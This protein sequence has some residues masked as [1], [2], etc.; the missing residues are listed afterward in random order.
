MRYSDTELLNLDITWFAVD[1]AGYVGCFA[2]NGTRLVPEVARSTAEGYGSLAGR[3]LDLI[4]L[5]GSSRYVGTCKKI[6][7]FLRTASPVQRQRYFSST[8]VWSDRGIFSYD[9]LDHNPEGY[10]LVSEPTNPLVVDLIPPGLRLLVE[11]VT[12]PFRFASALT[13]PKEAF[14]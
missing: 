10:F 8:F 11:K 5:T 2:T 3:I 13:V 4:P 7:D 12:F 6:N 14:L 9:C 1:A